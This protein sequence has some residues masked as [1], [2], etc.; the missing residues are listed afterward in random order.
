MVGISTPVRLFEVNSFRSEVSDQ[1]LEKIAKFEAGIDA[2]EAQD[3]DRA[4]GLFHEVLAFD[5]TDGPAR[6]FLERAEANKAQPVGESWDGVFSMT[7]K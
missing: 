2:Y 1:T 7:S 5:P 6:T 4:R 3:W